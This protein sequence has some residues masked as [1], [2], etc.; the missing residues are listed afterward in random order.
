MDCYRRI[1]WRLLVRSVLVEV[2]WT[3]KDLQRF[4]I[5]WIISPLLKLLYPED[6]RTIR[7]MYAEKLFNTT[8]IA[9]P[10]LVGLIWNLEEKVK[11]N[12]LSRDELF[13]KVQM[14]QA[15]LAAVGDT[16]FWSS[17]Y[18]FFV[19]LGIFLLGL[20]LKEVLVFGGV[21]WMI[22]LIVM[23]AFLL[24]KAYAGGEQFFFEVSGFP[25]L[26]FSKAIRGIGFALAVVML[27]YF[28]L[29]FSSVGLIFK[30]L[31][32]VYGIFFVLL[33]EEA[34]VIILSFLTYIV[35]ILIVRYG[36]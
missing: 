4:S 25:Y 1:F 7:A 6:W 33:S 27:V 22:F 16:L 28:P 10:A 18:L 11:D 5:A 8:F 24:R 32:L 30:L 3:R 21:L 29:T 15:P 12:R 31:G 23:R 26:K 34:G 35:M 20:S 14:L 19:L 9:V 17:L 13:Y 2:F 36:V